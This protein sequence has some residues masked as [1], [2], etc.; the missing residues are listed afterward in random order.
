MTG[1][2]FTYRSARSGSLLTG[3]GIALLAETLVL[4]L[5]IVGRHPLIAWVLTAI[6]IATLAWLAADYVAMGGGAIRLEGEH[7]R[8]DVGRRFALRVPRSSLASVVQPEWR[9]VPEA[10][11]SAASDYLNLMKPAAPNVLLTL[12]EPSRVR[13]AGGILRTVRRIGLHVDEPQRL[14]EAL[15]GDGPCRTELHTGCSESSTPSY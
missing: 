9:D 11:T 8:L 15:E 10:G 1:Q 7:L 14:V 2:N 12:T 13:I 4:H 3:I 5:W 6:S